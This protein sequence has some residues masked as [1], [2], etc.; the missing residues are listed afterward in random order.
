MTARLAGTLYRGSDEFRAI[1][2]DL[3]PARRD[4]LARLADWVDT[5]EGAGLVKLATYRGKEGMTTL[6]PRLAADN[7][8]LVTIPAKTGPR[9]CSSGAACSRP[10][11]KP[12]D[13]TA[14]ASSG[15]ERRTDRAVPHR[16]ESSA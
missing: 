13:V 7:A 6:L 9:T 8:G 14:T 5:L 11:R 10:V 1:I 3:P 15:S 4:V 16:T 2:A 12:S